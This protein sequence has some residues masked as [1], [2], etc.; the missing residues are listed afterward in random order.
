M[1]FDAVG[2]VVMISGPGD[3]A[4]EVAVV[5]RVI[6]KWNSEHSATTGVVFVPKH[7]STNTVPIYSKGTDG[8]A[9][10]NEQITNDSDVVVCLFKHRLGTPTPRNEHSG[11]AEEADARQADGLVHV[12]FWVGTDYPADLVDDPDRMQEWQRLK[13]FRSLFHNNDRGLYSTYES[14]ERLREQVESALWNDARAFQSNRAAKPVDVVSS[15]TKPTVDVVVSGNVWCARELRGILDN[16]IE[17]D[18]ESERQWAASWRDTPDAGL[19][20]ILAPL[21]TGSVRRVPK[22]QAE[23]DEWADGVRSRINEFDKAVASSAGTSIQVSL[24]CETILKDVEVEFIFAGVSGTDPTKSSWPDLWTP[25]HV[26]PSPEDFLGY[27]RIKPMDID[28]R[29]IGPITSHW[30]QDGD[31]VVL[32][33]ALH[34]LR[35]RRLPATF[36]DPVILTLP[37][38][39]DAPSEISYTWRVSASNSNQEWAGKGTIPVLNEAR[40]ELVAWL[41]ATGRD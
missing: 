5:R 36:D 23:I 26:P 37:C 35:N 3:T 33:L 13:D 14:T 16:A 32:T 15:T 41:R 21:P 39:A 17:G 27:E 31:D 38:T 20:A 6:E 19:R 18:I 29:A 12:Y 11:T 7:Y 4:D 30:E 10:I 40:S 24:N 8:Q 2:V 22:T 1:S 28:Y 25:L 9:I 34:E